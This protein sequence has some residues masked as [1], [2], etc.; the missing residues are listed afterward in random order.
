MRLRRQ[1]A[2]F[3]IKGCGLRKLHDSRAQKLIRTILDE[4]DLQHVRDTH[5][6]RSFD[7]REGMYRFVH[8]SCVNGEAIDYLE[9]G[10]FQGDS[11]RYWTGLNTHKDSRFYGFD[12]FEGLPEDWR[13]GQT[14]GHFDVGGTM[15]R[16]DD[17]RVRFVKGWFDDT[18]PPFAR[19]FQPRNRLVMHLDADLYG[20]TML[21]LLHFGSFMANGTLL[22]FDEFYDRDHEFKALMDWQKIYRRNYRIIAQMQNYSKVCAQL[23]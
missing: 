21:P 23:M 11:I 19:E 1:I 4:I 9:F 5:P 8:E 14:K 15:P 2:D 7:S 18:V 13:G 16:I 22:I 17:A 6:C 12:S 3:F 20:S 10:V